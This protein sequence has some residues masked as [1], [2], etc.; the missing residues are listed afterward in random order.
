M[1]GIDEIAGDMSPLGIAAFISSLFVFTAYYFYRV[2]R[3]GVMTMDVWIVLYLGLSQNFLFI[4]VAYSSLNAALLGSAYDDFIASVDTTVWI[5]SV[6]AIIF[7]FGAI[8]GW[9][10]K[11]RA[12]LGFRALY[13]VV[14][15]FWLT[16][17]GPALGLTILVGLCVL[18]ELQGVGFGQGRAA[19]IEDRSLQPL[20]N[21]MNACAQLFVLLGLFRLVKRRSIG[22]LLTLILTV[23]LSFFG[24]TR[25]ASVWPLL[26]GGAILMQVFRV[27][28]VVPMLAA[29]AA[30]TVFSVA[31]GNFRNDGSLNLSISADFLQDLLFGGNLTEQRDFAWVYS[32]WDHTYLY[33]KSYLA[34]LLG[35]VPSSLSDFRQEWSWGRVTARAV[36]LDPAT[37]SGFRLPI[38]G[39]AYFNFSWPGVV[40]V[41]FYLGYTTFR[42]SRFIDHALRNGDRASAVT[43]GATC[44]V[45]LNCVQLAVVSVT[46]FVV[47][48]HIAVLITG[49]LL[50]RLRTAGYSPPISRN[51]T[52]EKELSR[53]STS[54]KPYKKGGTL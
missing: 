7:I 48:V 28:R 16:K 32:V 5:S 2:R 50:S 41:A 3:S 53:I 17:S 40:V 25:S 30:L 22:S 18:L 27:R 46:I 39:E 10:S 43:L 35:F 1:P 13:K 23:L 8:L 24:G 47:Y 49:G 31:F 29:L 36:G 42:L 52:E 19:V 21:L 14:D 34:G 45:Y 20:N 38:V 12:P 37:F 4:P 6:G 9:K 44:A 15:R 26:L 54:L 11:G 51:R 33:G